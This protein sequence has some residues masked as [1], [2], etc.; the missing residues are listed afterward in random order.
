MI[1]ENKNQG[2]TLIELI[3]IIIILAI[4]ASVSLPKFANFKTQAIE[5]QEDSVVAALKTAIQT[6]HLSYVVKGY[7]DSWPQEVPFS[8]LVQAPSNKYYGGLWYET[9][10]YAPDNEN[11]RWNWHSGGVATFIFCP[12]WNGTNQG[13]GASKGRF[14]IY[15][16]AVYGGWG[17]KPGDF[18]FYPS[19]DYGH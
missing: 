13:T 16:C 5:K 8:L 9:V 11:W 10:T 12:H 3:M 4:F 1:I 15:Q 17:A 19:V 6:A 2:F 14:I 18:G 7:E